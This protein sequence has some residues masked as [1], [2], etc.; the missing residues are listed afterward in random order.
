VECKTEETPVTI[1]PNGTISYSFRKYLINLPGKHDVKDLQKT[2]TLVIAH[3]LREVL[4]YTYKTFVMGNNS[5]CAVYCKH[6]VS[7]ALCT[8]ETTSFVPDI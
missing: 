6:R 7:A 5:A 1:G 8:S 2:A 3:V 4:M